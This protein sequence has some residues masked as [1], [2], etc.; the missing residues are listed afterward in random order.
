MPKEPKA[1]KT[2]VS[3]EKT[4][5][6]IK[7]PHC[8]SENVYGVSRVVGYYSKIENWNTGK[9]V[10]FKDRQKGNYEVGEKDKK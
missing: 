8:G 1:T 9:K 7:C 5:L 4:H 6:K 2:K 3:E 10:E